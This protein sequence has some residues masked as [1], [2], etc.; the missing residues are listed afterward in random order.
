MNGRL[1]KIVDVIIGLLFLGSEMLSSIGVSFFCMLGISG[2]F[3]H[4]PNHFLAQSYYQI[5][6]DYYRLAWYLVSPEINLHLRYIPISARARVHFAD[7]QVL[8]HWGLCLT[9]LSLCVLIFCYRYEKKRYQLWQLIPLWWQCL[10]L[11]IIVCCLVVVSFQD[12]FLWFHYH[13]FHNMDWVFSASR[14]PIILVLT[15]RFFLTY[16]VGW[17]L[18]VLLINILLLIKA[19]RLI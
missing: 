11:L 18:L 10:I 13:F 15:R 2:V 17:A 19:K 16:F 3:L 1:S 9:I 6:S 5:M 7:V 4:L 12:T 14:D 8:V